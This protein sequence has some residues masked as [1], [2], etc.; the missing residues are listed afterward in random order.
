MNRLIVFLMASILVADLAI[1]GYSQAVLAAAPVTKMDWPAKGKAITMIVPASPGGT[2]DPAARV[3]AVALEKALGTSVQVLNKPGAS[4]Q[5]GLTELAKAEP[6]GY[7]IGYIILPS[8]FNTYLDSKRKATYTRK[9]FQILAGH[10]VSP[11]VIWVK[12]DSPYKTVKDLIDA[13]RANPAKIKTA[14]SGVLG[15]SH[16]AL[17][18]LGKA[19]NV[20]FA[21]VQFQG[22]GP[23]MTALLGGHVDAA[24]SPV[25]EGVEKKSLIRG[26]G[27]M[28]SRESSYLPGVKTLESQGYKIYVSSA[29]GLATPAGTPK[30]VMDILTRAMKKA[31]ERP[32]HKEKMENIGLG[33]RYMDP[34]QFETFWSNYETEVKPLLG[35]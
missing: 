1:M 32:E 34:I 10:Y 26:L 13:A 16:L 29:G 2:T 27:V 14:A 28:D 3:L 8:A 18:Q 19:A 11:V 35:F 20:K 5:V 17:L 24:I 12:Q 25:T 21:I 23:G 6:D 33:V 22:G 4:T 31:M 15:L 7:T 30:E 9:S